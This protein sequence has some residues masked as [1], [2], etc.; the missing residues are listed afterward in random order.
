MFPPPSELQLPA[1]MTRQRAARARTRRGT[2]LPGGRLRTALAKSRIIRRA[3]RPSPGGP[4][5]IV[6]DKEAPVAEAAA[7]VVSVKVVV[8]LPA[9][10]VALAGENVAAH[11]LGRPAQLNV[12]VESN[13]PYWGA[14]VIV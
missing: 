7:F 2:I 12:M 11:L 3:K 10:G 1:M 6:P 8:T 14:K 9:P 5:P 4:N 13:D